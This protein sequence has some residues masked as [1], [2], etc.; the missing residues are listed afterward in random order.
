[1][2]Q[3]VIANLGLGQFTIYGC[4]DA[5]SKE[6]DSDVAETL[7]LPKARRYL[8]TLRQLERLY[9]QYVSGR[10]KKNVLIKVKM[11]VETYCLVARDGVVGLMSVNHHRTTRDPADVLA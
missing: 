1:M 9:H 11:Q 4:L 7:L 2:N 8:E 6:L 5:H 10:K 3:C